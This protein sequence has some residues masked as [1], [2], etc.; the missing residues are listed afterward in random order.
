MLEA[1][2]QA[3]YVRIAPRKVRVVL[4]LIRGKNVDEA[5]NILRFTPRASSKVIEKLVMSAAANAENNH[6]M[7]RDAL[8]ITEC[9]ADQ[10][11]IIKRYRPRAMGR[12]SSIQKKTSHI[13][14]KLKE[15]EG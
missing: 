5:L 15:K 7:N 1:R 10:G 2:A 14:I 13:T 3:R 9:Y 8:Y 4:D 11:P 12:A 6:D